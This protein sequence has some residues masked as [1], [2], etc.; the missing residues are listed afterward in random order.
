MN[1]SPTPDISIIGLGIKGVEH[2]TREAEAVC[3]GSNEILAV[4]AHPAVLDHLSSLCPTVTEL[5][6]VSADGSRREAYETMAATVLAAALDHAPVT[7]APYGHPLV[8]VQASRRILQAAPYLGLRV[9]VLPGIS[10]L[11]TM[12]VDLRLDPAAHGLQLYE[13]TD[14]LLRRR[15]LQPDVPCLLLQVGTVESALPAAGPNRAGRFRRIEDYLLGF[16][17]PE[18]R[19]AAVYSTH[20]PLLASSITWFALSDLDAHHGDLV[21]GLTLYIPPVGERPVADPDLAA[22]LGS[23][24][25]LARITTRERS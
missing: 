24:A 15:P 14:V 20:H 11:D 21:E 10:S 22:T 23:A 18:H 1:R 25:H 13:A 7:F 19:L 16:Y 3:R 4:P 12:F 6:S 17:P 8:Y 9:R 2:L 5:P